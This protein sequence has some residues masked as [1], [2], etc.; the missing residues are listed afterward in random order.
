MEQKDFMSESYLADLELKELGAASVDIGHP[1][2]QV[3][4]Q[5]LAVY[6]LQNKL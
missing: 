1:A 4:G 6:L 5:L 2:P 3:Y